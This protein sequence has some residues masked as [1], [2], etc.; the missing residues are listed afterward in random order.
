MADMSAERTVKLMAG[1]GATVDAPVHLLVGYSGLMKGMCGENGEMPDMVPL[2]N[3]RGYRLQQALSVMAMHHTKPMGEIKRPLVDNSLAK[4]MDHP[5]LAAYADALSTEEAMELL[6]LA[7]YIDCNPLLHLMAA[8]LATGMRGLTPAQIRE[9][10]GIENDF[11]PEQ[12]AAI[13]EENRWCD[14]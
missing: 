1:D 10:Y 6:M 4:S 7:N 9:K 13:A 14:V 2:P 12:E 5:D 11:T 8:K 3:A